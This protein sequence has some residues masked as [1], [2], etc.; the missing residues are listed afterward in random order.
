[1]K[2]YNKDEIKN[3]L[4]FQQVFEYVAELG[5]NPKLDPTGAEVFMAQTICHNP[6]GTGSHK[7]YYYQNTHLFHCW[8]ECGDSFDIFDLTRKW[9]KQRSEEWSLPRA[10]GYVAR[11]FG[12]ASSEEENFDDTQQKLQDWEVLKNYQQNSSINNSK[13]IVEFK[14]FDENILQYLPRPAITPW[15]NEGIKQEIMNARGICYDP[16][17]CG[18][19]IPHYDENGAL[20]G[21]RE[22]TLIK[23]E[24]AYGKYRP[25]VLNGKMYNHPLGFA[26]YNLNFSKGNIRKFQTAIVFEGEKSCLK[27]ASMFGADSDISV[28]TC[29]SNLIQHQVDLLTQPWMAK[30]IVIAFDKQFKEVGDQEYKQWTRKLT[31]LHNKYSKLVNISF[32]FDVKGDMLGYKESPVDRDKETFVKLFK[33]RVRL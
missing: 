1:M 32:I 30:E 27:Y 17:N 28:A 12:I 15:I 31:A 13:K 7:L 33:E 20:I 22:R 8:T 24:E 11:Y 5:G 3:T 4:T 16:V 9:A 10:V 18:I 25:A 29:G 14:E 19:V 2:K 26:L 6:A 21:I 23:E